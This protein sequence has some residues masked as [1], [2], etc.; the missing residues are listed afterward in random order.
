MIGAVAYSTAL[1]LAWVSPPLALTL[2]GATALYDA[3]DQASVPTEQAP[4][5]QRPAGPAA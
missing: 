5:D 4:A 1:C 3:F 2:H